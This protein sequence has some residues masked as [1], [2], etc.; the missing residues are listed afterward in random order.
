MIKSIANRNVSIIIPCYNVEAWIDRCIQSIINQTVDIDCFEIICVDDCS[1]DSTIAHLYEWEKKFPDNFIIVECEVNGRQGRARNIGLQYASGEWIG[2]IDADDWIEP[3]Y[4]EC[5]LQVTEKEDC[6]LVCCGYDRDYAKELSSFAEGDNGYKY[7]CVEVKNDDIRREI[8]ISAPLKYCA[9]AKII[10]KEMLVNNDIYFP[11]NIT[12]EDAVWGSLL[13]L[14]FDKAAIV[15]K[16][17]YH[18]FVNDNSTI[19]RLDSFHHFDSITSQTILW[20]EYEKRGML[21]RYREEL[22]LEH[23][24]SACLPA[25]KASILRYTIPNYNMYL[26]IRTIMKDRIGNYAENSYVKKGLLS[27]VHLLLMKSI[28]LELTRNEYLELAK[29]IKRIGL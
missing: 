22:E 18:Y 4:F 26:L 14:Y 9:W 28:D 24:Y 17:L 25:L 5:M 6:D 20:G 12:Y 2:F 23:I 13:H 3:D 8:I 10:K 15:E 7:S 21:K 1:T 19:L 29:N 16:K 27:E 11:A